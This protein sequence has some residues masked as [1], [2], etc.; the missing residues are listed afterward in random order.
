MSGRG[1]VPDH[2]YCIYEAC[3]PPCYIC[4]LLSIVESVLLE[5]VLLSYFWFA[6]V[7][8]TSSEQTPAQVTTQIL[9][10]R[11]PGILQ[12][13]TLMTLYFQHLRSPYILGLT[14]RHECS[15]YMTHV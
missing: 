1:V 2:T 6:W 7:V 13:I 4:K 8:F 9:L 11:R 5:Y 15:R 12:Y 14:T 3:H 10:I